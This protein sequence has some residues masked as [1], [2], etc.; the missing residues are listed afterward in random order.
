[1]LV[2]NANR[3]FS[4]LGAPLKIFSIEE[5]AQFAWAH[6]AAWGDTSHEWF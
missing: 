2:Q 6:F 3:Q 5:L 1:M 4:A